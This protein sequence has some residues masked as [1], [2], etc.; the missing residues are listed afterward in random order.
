VVGA[1]VVMVVVMMM[2][3]MRPYLYDYLSIG[4]RVQGE[5]H[6]QRTQCEQTSLDVNVH[7]RLPGINFCASYRRW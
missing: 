7:E 5:A 2:V 4:R 1:V 6:A 3:M